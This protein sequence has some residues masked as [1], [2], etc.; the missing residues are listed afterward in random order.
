MK[1][2][3][4][5]SKYIFYGV[6]G[7]EKSMY[8]ILKDKNNQ[9][10]DIELIGIKDPK[11]FNSSMYEMKFLQEW[12]KS[13][14]TLN[15]QFKRFFYLEYCLNKSNIVNFFKKL[16]ANAEVYAYGFYAAAAAIGFSGKTTI[17][18][19][20]ESDLG[21]ND[22]YYSGIKRILKFVYYILEYPFYLVYLKDLKLSYA[23]SNL[24]F[25]SVWM[26]KECSNRFG[27]KG[28]VVYPTVDVKSLKENFSKNKDV[29]NKGIVFI[30]DAEVKGLSIVKSIAKIM[31]NE[32]FI[33]FNRNVIEKRIDDN[34]TYM[35]WSTDSSYPYKFAKLLIVPSIWNEAFGRVSIEA[36]A[37]GIPVIVSN[38][39]GLP[40]TVGF[41]MDFIVVNNLDSKEWVKKIEKVLS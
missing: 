24:I 28:I 2:I 29:E 30:G 18:L 40:E 33:I 6:G 5:F 15:F 37:L 22:N 27:Y 9:G 14:L 7:A 41:N 31:Q 39:G 32:K 35:P 4:A 26:S 3:I 1:K 10:F 36:Q 34:I 25:N 13:H 20:S 16:D 21:I 38:R 19:R 17:Y 11:N 23:K 12:K 8:E